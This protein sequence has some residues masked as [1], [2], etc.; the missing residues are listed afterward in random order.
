MKVLLSSLCFWLLAYCHSEGP[1]KAVFFGMP[2][3]CKDLQVSDAVHEIGG[4]C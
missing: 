4:A 3:V 1:L 2:R